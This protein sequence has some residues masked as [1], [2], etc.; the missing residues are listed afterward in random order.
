MEVSNVD[1]RLVHEG[2]IK[3]GDFVLSDP[4]DPMLPAAMVIGKVKSIRTDRAN[5]LLDILTIESSVNQKSLRRVFVYSPLAPAL[6]RT[7]SSE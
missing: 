7:S 4:A 6:E 3:T 5:P 1:R 2:G